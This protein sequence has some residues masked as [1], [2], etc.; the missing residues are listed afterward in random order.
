MREHTGEESQPDD[1]ERREVQTKPEAS[2]E[3][4]NSDSDS[5]KEPDSESRAKDAKDIQVQ[6]ELTGES[7]PNDKERQKE[8]NEKLVEAA[9]DG[10]NEDVIQHISNGAEITSK[11]SRGLTGLH[12]SAEFGYLDVLETFITHTADLNIR[13]CNQL[14]PLTFAAYCRQL[15]CAQLLLAHGAD[16]DLQDVNGMTALM[17]A[18]PVG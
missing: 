16:T 12:I 7:R 1:E 6:R 4:Y 10:K 2:E 17:Y 5:G 11:D 3:D 13:G 8:I 18:A 15:S 9:W 14:T